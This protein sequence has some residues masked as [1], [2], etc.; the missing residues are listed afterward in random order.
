MSVVVHHV[1]RHKF[2]GLTTGDYL[3]KEKHG[4]Y[5]GHTVGVLLNEPFTKSVD[6]LYFRF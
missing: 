3:P 6:H 5:I 1:K 4:G 2:I